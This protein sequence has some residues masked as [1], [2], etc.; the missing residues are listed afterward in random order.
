[1]HILEEALATP[2]PAWHYE[3]T[4][5]SHRINESFALY[6]LCL[7]AYLEQEEGITP[8]TIIVEGVTERLRSV[9]A[10]GQEPECQGG[11]GG[12]SHGS[13]AWS[14]GFIRHTQALWEALSPAEQ[15]KAD[16]LMQALAVASCFCMDDDNDYRTMLDGDRNFRKYMNPNHQEGYVAA[17]LSAAWYFGNDELNR[18]LMQFDFDAFLEQLRQAGFTNIVACWTRIPETRRVLMEGGAYHGEE[19]LDYG[20]G[21]GVHGNHFTY[22]GLELSDAWGIYRKM[23]A[24]LFDHTAQ[25]EIPVTGIP[26]LFTHILERDAEG[27]Y[28]ISPYEGQFGMCHEFK[29]TNAEKRGSNFRSSLFYVYEGWMNN[30][31]TATAIIARGQWDPQGDE[32]DALLDAIRVGTGDFHYKAEHGYF[33]FANGK[34]QP[35]NA[36]AIAKHTGGWS[37]SHCWW[38][39]IVEPALEF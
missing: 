23:A 1:M 14:L 4:V 8:N 32:D 13:F 7:E 28:L 33:G 18:R 10:G 34:E 31:A 21:A 20:S 3:H 22:K 36:T 26:E 11:L 30:M 9:M 19:D 29:S 27:N 38:E 37:F 15:A 6:T 25:T 35:A 5:R 39:E 16:L 2:A 24:R 12:W 17:G